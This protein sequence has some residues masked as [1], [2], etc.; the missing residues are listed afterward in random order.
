MLTLKS[1]GM[2]VTVQLVT[3]VVWF[4]ADTRKN[5]LYVPGIV[6][7]GT[8]PCH[9]PASSRNEHVSALRSGLTSPVTLVTTAGTTGSPV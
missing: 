7:V 8:V 4:G 9:S 5:S 3:Y 2:I 6:N 1:H